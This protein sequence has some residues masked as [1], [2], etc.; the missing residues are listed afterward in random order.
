MY[1][2]IT[3][4]KYDKGKAR[5][6]LT[7]IVEGLHKR[8]IKADFKEIDKIKEINKNDIAI[9]YG[10]IRG[11]DIALNYCWEKNINYLY[12]DNSYFNNLTEE[13]MFRLIPNG[14][15]PKD[16]IPINSPKFK[17]A[18][19]N[20]YKEDGN[21]LVIPPSDTVQKLFSRKNWLDNTNNI[22]DKYTD[23]NIIIRT[24]P[25]VLKIKKFNGKLIKDVSV[26]V[27]SIPLDNHLKEAQ[28]VIADTSSVSVLALING[29]PVISNKYG[30]VGCI[31]ENYISNVDLV[32][33]PEED[34]LKERINQLTHYCFTKGELKSGEFHKHMIKFGLWSLK[35]T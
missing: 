26:K 4:D 18:Y 15:H 7:L 21:I 5:K 33:L 8:N 12:Y 34:K 24:K 30:P 10:L 11:S 9:I 29:I 3:L 31:T 2:G 6:H 28:C 22:L 23:K 20:Y 32:K 16:F 25:L 17:I 1:F 13:K 27:H 19:N 14:C 35:D